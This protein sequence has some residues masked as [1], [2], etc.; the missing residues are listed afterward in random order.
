MCH[1]DDCEAHE[2]VK[3]ITRLE[4]QLR[5]AA[6]TERLR[7]RDRWDRWA[8]WRDAPPEAAAAYDAGDMGEFIAW[9]TEDPT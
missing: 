5:D 1:T 3:D 9:L 8:D 7:I 6:T 4:V 2:L